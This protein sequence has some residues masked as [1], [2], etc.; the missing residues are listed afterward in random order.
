MA[1]SWLSVTVE[2]LAGRGKLYWPYPGRI[3][4]VGPA[5]TFAD[6]ALAINNAF[7]RW[8]LSHQ[9]LFTL[10]DGRAVTDV[11]IGHEQAASAF[12]PV[13]APALDLRTTRVQSTIKP[14]GEFRYVFD[15]GD[16][17][18][19]ACTVDSCLVDPEEVLGM[20]P[21]APT[22]SW[23]WGSLPDQYG[24]RWA[25]DDGESGIPAAPR[26]QHPMISMGWPNDDRPAPRVDLAA[27]RSA[28]AQDDALAI[29]AAIEGHD[30]ADLLQHAGAAVLAQLDRAPNRLDSLAFSLLGRLQDRDLPGDKELGEELLA[31]LRR[32]LPPGTSLPVDLDELSTLLEGDPVSDLGGFLDLETGDV[33]SRVLTDP[34]MVGDDAI[35]VEEDPERWLMV[36]CGDRTL[37]GRTWPPSP[38]AFRIRP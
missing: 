22:A 4:V 20:V 3:L 5:H 21:A 25:A 17:W 9:S 30:P 6:L 13:A 38:P 7:A 18:L 29:A 31:S 2:L 12:G 27:L 37:D 10:P 19:H 35:D 36:D 34:A 28:I 11:E 23:G 32:E 14:A 33:V 16:S 8:D 26:Q 24:R 1:R 15:F